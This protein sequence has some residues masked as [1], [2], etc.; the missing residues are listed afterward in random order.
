MGIKTKILLLIF[1]CF[2]TNQLSTRV[3]AQEQEKI[4][5][6]TFGQLEDS[7]KVKPK[8][9]FIDFY[10]DWCQQC[11]LMAENVFTDS[12]VI[13]LIND[14]YYAV[15]MDVETRDTIVFG[16]QTYTNER[17]EKRNPVH[18]IPLLMASQ[19]NKPFY[20]P[21]MVFLDENFV[22]T[23]RYFQYIDRESFVKILRSN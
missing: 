9:V 8:K 22:A 21:A 7:L 15:R 20:L 2:G 3:D 1:L 19:E 12:E 13:R 16:G 18:Q 6:I 11:K 17:T 14:E 4:N 23:S 10:S 5:W